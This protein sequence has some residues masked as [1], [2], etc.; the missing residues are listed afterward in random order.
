MPFDYQPTLKGTLVELRPLCAGD[1]DDLYSV[2]ADPLIWEQH[3]VRNRNEIGPF[4]EFFQDA[5]GS[6]GALIAT[7]ARTQRV[8]GLSRFH[9]YDAER[10]EV[11][12]GWTFLA[13]SYWGGKYN[14]ELKRLMLEHAFA[15]VR[16]VV[17]LVGPHNV[18]SQRAVEKVGAVRV[19]MRE[20][21]SGRRSHLY[22][23]TPSAFT[24]ED[25]T[26]C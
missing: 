22:Q 11:E 7:A 5:L 20:D 26:P 17:F 3:P 9:G 8:I 14:G 18:R 2:A 6:G 15:F 4:R 23:I 25:G 19:G 1:F 21:A 10:G 12:I 13:R 16:C 24:R